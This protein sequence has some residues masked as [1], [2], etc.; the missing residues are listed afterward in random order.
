MA[1]TRV[2]AESASGPARPGR[3]AP[4]LVVATVLAATAYP[5]AMSLH[6]EGMQGAFRYFAADTFYYLSVADRSAEQGFFTFDGTHPTNGFHPLWQFYLER[7]FS[8]LD[9]DAAGQ[10]AFAAVSSTAFVA[11]GTALFAL[12]LLRLTRRPWLAILGAVPGVYYLLVPTLNAHHFSQ[13]SFANGMESP[14]SIFFFGMLLLGIFV[15]GW[16]EESPSLRPLVALSVVLAALVLSRLDDVFILIPF[17]LWAALGGVSRADAIRRTVAVTAVTAVPAIGIGCYL[18]YNLLYA[19]SL[20]PTSGAAKAQPL[21]GLVRNLYAVWTTALPFA[22]PLARN[23]AVWES[24]AWRVLQMLVP[25]GA[26]V[27]WLGGRRMTLRAKGA[28]ETRTNGLIGLLAAYVLVK[29]AYNFSMV[30]LWNQGQWYYP[31]SIMTFN[32]IAVGWLA[33]LLDQRASIGRA[34]VT[35]G[36][37]TLLGLLRARWP[38]IGRCVEAVPL[39]SALL[40]VLVSANAFVDLKQSGRHQ[41]R[42]FEFWLER[43]STRHLLEKTCPGCGVL[44]FDDGI[45]AYSLEK[46]PTLN[47]LGLVLDREAQAAQE[48]GRLLDVAWARGHRVL[49]SVNYAMPREAYTSPALL[50]ESLRGNRHLEGQDVDEWNFEVA[51]RSPSTGVSFVRFEPRHHAVN[52]PARA[53]SRSAQVARPARV[54]R[55][56]SA[57]IVSAPATPPASSRAP[58]TRPG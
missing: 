5:P 11:L 51:F 1:R 31:L 9:L 18:G 52:A 50:R 3:L 57:P 42:N 28:K 35:A 29:A 58:S 17:A 55:R 40:V 20:L 27:A 26:A 45:V 33:A 56:A 30:G 12:A 2:E 15:R 46:T 34:A 4:W 47:G 8:L 7:G 39:A 43:E 25:A 16:L 23:V 48:S 54:H 36:E 41:S 37:G 53:S 24:E 38:A 10:V 13:W 32:L 6:R 22:D 14:L 49:V 19:E 44:A 21:W